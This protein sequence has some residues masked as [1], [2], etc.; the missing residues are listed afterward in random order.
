[1]PL[2]DHVSP[3]DWKHAW[4]YISRDDLDIEWRQCGD[5]GKEIE[6]LSVGHDLRAAEFERVKALDL[7]VPANQ[8]EAQALLDQ[9]AGL[10][11]REGYPYVELSDLEGIRVAARTPAPTLPALNLTAAQLEDK[12]YGAWLGRACGCLLGKPVEGWHRARM[13]G[14]LKDTGRFP[15][16]DY[17]SLNV[18]EAVRQEYGVSTDRAFIETVHYMPEDDDLNYTVA[19]LALLKQHGRTF[20]PADVAHFWLENIPIL[21]TCTAERVA[22]RNFCLQ[23][24]PPFSASHRNPY[25]EWIGAQIRGDL[26]GYVSPGRPDLASEFAWRDAC[27]SHVKNGIYGEMWVAAVLAAAFVPARTGGTDDITTIINAGLAQIPVRSRFYEHIRSV[28]E[29][30]AAGIGYDEAVERIHHLWDETRPYDW[31]H[32]ISNAM[33]VAVG[34]LWGGLDYGRS[35]CRAVQACF[36]TDCNGATVGSIVGAV[37]GAKNLPPK[38]TAPIHDT[39]ETCLPDYR[40]VRISSL[41]RETLS[42]TQFCGTFWT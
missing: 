3:K 11:I 17:F 14:Y 26:F 38:W 4:L 20:T 2:E 8:R 16:S 31:C 18:P 21:R 28:M 6:R 1:M 5:E 12:L 13:W 19:N 35:I 15:L 36:D 37:L 30:H 33:I 9:T 22:Y 42:A 27:I 40:R 25:R 24:P 7:E 32:V 34:L 41:A 29:W 10:P 39:L 23:I